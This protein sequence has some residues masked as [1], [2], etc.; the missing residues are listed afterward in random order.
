[1]VFR[2]ANDGDA[3]AEAVGDG[4]LGN[5]VSGVVGALGVDIGAQFLQK[6]LD[7]G[8]GE[9]HNVI[10]DAE[11][12]DDKR[13]GMF[14]EDG[15]AGTFQR[16]DTGIGVDADN[17]DVSFGLGS[18]QIADM[19]NVKRVET[20]VGED[21][22]LPTELRRGQEFAEKFARNDF[23]L[24]GT[25]ELR[26]SLRGRGADGGEEFGAGN[27]GGAALHD[28]EAAGDVGEVR[29]FERRSAAGKAESVGGENGVAGAG[30]VHGL[31]AAMDGDVH[32]FLSGLKE[33]DAVA[34]SS[35]DE[36]LEFQVG[37]GGAA[38]A[39]EFSEIFADG[40]VVKGFHFTFIG[41]GGMEAGAGVVGEAV[42]RIERGDGAALTAGEEFAEFGGNGDAEAVVGNG[43]GVGFLEGVGE[44]GVNFFVDVGGKGV[45]GFVVHAEDLLAD[46]VSPSG[47]EAGFGRGG[48]APGAKDAGDVHSLRA[49]EFAEA[50]SGQV[51][52]DGGDGNDFGSKGGE[53]VGRVGAASGN[54]L[55]FTMLED[56]NGSFA[57]DPGD[58]AELEGVGDEIA[59]D[60]DAFGGEAL[61]VFREGEEVDGGGGGL[62]R[63][64]LHEGSLDGMF[65][66]V[67]GTIRERGRGF[68]AGA[69]RLPDRIG[70]SGVRT[71]YAE[72][73][74]GAS[75]GGPHAC[76]L[77]AG[78]TTEG[79]L[80][81]PLPESR[82]LRTRH[83]VE[84]GE[85]GGF[86]QGW[87]DGGHAAMIGGAAT[88]EAGATVGLLLDEGGSGRDGSCAVRIGGAK[89]GDDGEADGGGDVH[90]SRI[91]AEEE[92]ALREERG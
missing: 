33:G 77:E 24:G 42:T 54:D 16:A 80:K 67:R 56:Q 64:A 34:A 86:D 10:H 52:T 35:D 65:I 28:H 4:A 48:P 13:A 62:G 91:V 21:D 11:G 47:E 9:E 41:C 55:S 19:A 58:V 29:G 57:G 72:E 18:G 38:A 45:A 84:A 70:W 76:L 1:M 85:E 82:A 79:G 50:I 81:P 31:I 66:S 90:G 71:L 12:G 83:P 61:D 59:Q 23:R 89:D 39:F 88:E 5:R 32:G 2:I 60:N 53:I 40:G 27:G 87:A 22:R 3:D 26:G 37:E 7:V 25:H 8:F 14:V 20:A 30:D 63:R 46:F 51:I 15:T 43:D 69:A 6:F 36:G 92:M 75:E 17:E 49:E 74:R 78:A 44:L 68:K 73:Q